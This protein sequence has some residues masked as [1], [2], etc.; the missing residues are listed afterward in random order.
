MF[1]ES[2]KICNEGLRKVCDNSTVGAG[3]E[4]SNNQY[5]ANCSYWSICKVCKTHYETTCET[6]F[7]E[8]EVEQDEPVCTMVTERKCKD[9]R[10]E[11]TKVG[12]S[13]HL[14]GFH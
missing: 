6:R 3:E 1:E 12:K 2:V 7:K 9:V 8:H 5:K 13:I 14:G 10:G 11:K 4:V